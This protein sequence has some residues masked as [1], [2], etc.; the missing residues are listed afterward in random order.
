MRTLLNHGSP[1]DASNE[2][3]QTP[4]HLA[5]ALLSGR[6]DHLQESIVRALLEHGSRVDIHNLEGYHA[7]H[8]A[9]IWSCGDSVLVRI[10][11]QYAKGLQQGTVDRKF[12]QSSTT[13]LQAFFTSTECDE[14]LSVS[15]LESCQADSEELSGRA[16][17]AEAAR[18]ISSVV[19]Q[20][21]KRHQIPIDCIASNG[22]SP[23]HTAIL[24][25]RADRVELLLQAG[26]NIVPRDM[27]DLDS[28]MRC[29][30][31]TV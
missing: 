7:L 31:I 15:K 8:Y 1:A 3:G 28:L 18:S 4:L 21:V 6:P 13:S 11:N 24:N 14:L 9:W 30:S 20:S 19:F 5:L 27:L 10:S 29:S 12:V 25:E 2:R 16:P 26:V 22:E 23:V 17:L